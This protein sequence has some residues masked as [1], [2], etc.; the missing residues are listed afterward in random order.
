MKIITFECV[1]LCVCVCLEIGLPCV[2][3]RPRQLRRERY[4]IPYVCSR[5]LSPKRKLN[6]SVSGSSSTHSWLYQW[7]FQ[8]TPFVD[9]WWDLQRWCANQISVKISK[10]FVIFLLSKEI[11]WKL[12]K[13]GWCENTSTK[14]TTSTIQ[15]ARRDS[16]SPAE[17]GFSIS[18]NAFAHLSNARFATRKQECLILADRQCCV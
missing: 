10:C 13:C 2:P 18:N 6:A 3:S 16:M 17:N 4:D 9:V 5:Q 7:H 11:N 14:K 1:Y 12:W 15:N 8:A